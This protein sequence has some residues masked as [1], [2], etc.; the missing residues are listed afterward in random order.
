MKI[1]EIQYAPTFTKAEWDKVEP[2]T[3]FKAED[4]IPYYKKM[5]GKV[6]SVER[7]WQFIA[8]QKKER[9][10]QAALQERMGPPAN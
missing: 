5:N 8:K 2:S 4:G 7:L 9:A 6:V 10:E 1:S 3:V